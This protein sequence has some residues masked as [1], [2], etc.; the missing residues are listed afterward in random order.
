MPCHSE[1]W[2]LPEVQTCQYVCLRQTP[3]S[4]WCSGQNKCLS[5][6]LLIGIHHRLGCWIP[7]VS[8]FGV[9]RFLCVWT[10]KCKQKA[11][12]MCP[13][14]TE[15]YQ[16]I[17]AW[18]HHWWQHYVVNLSQCILESHHIQLKAMVRE[19]MPSV[20]PAF[21]RHLAQGV[22]WISFILKGISGSPD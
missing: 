14:E 18:K 17:H 1:G 8:R 21:S 15:M 22:S 11:F 2:Q 5:I 9:W 12:C 10:S 19:H 7:F 13:K 16:L 4:L 20:K 3:V 6:P